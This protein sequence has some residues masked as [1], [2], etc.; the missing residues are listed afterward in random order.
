MITYTGK[1]QIFEYDLNILESEGKLEP[2]K[3]YMA[4]RLGD[5]KKVKFK[6]FWR[7]EEDLNCENFPVLELKA[8][9]FVGFE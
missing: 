4:H 1:Y 5:V 8:Q 3:N 6:Q 7:E 2:E 9:I